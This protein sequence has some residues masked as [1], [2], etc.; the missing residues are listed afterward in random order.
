MG[1]DTHDSGSAGHV[2]VA[3][4]AEC[5]AIAD[6]LLAAGQLHID[7]AR[8]LR[9][10]V[11]AG[12]FRV[13]RVGEPVEAQ[14]ALLRLIPGNPQVLVRAGSPSAARRLL[15]ALPR[16]RGFELWAFD[17]WTADLAGE[18]LQ[19][20]FVERRWYHVV[21]SAAFRP[22][23]PSAARKLTGED[24]SLVSR[25]PNDYARRLFDMEMEYPYGLQMFGVVQGDELLSFAA[26][27]PKEHVPEVIWV[28]TSEPYRRQGHGKAVVS[29]AVA[30]KLA[31]GASMVHYSG[32]AEGNAASMRLCRSIGFEPVGCATVYSCPPLGA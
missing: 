8:P 27:S 28:T 25:F 6:A 4:P 21:S 20:E 14:V 16:D 22:F 19:A 7:L 3:D 18:A 23:N 15:E 5:G 32:V 30:E 12:E 29:R 24:A 9:A 13:L 26:A 10:R 2:V 31:A 1:P 11:H 17:P